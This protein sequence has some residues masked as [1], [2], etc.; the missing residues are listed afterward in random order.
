MECIFVYTDIKKKQAEVSNRMNQH[1][2]Y[3]CTK[4]KEEKQNNFFTHIIISTGDQGGLFPFF[5]FL[6]ILII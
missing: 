6:P 4:I 3:I 2:M 1:P 5:S